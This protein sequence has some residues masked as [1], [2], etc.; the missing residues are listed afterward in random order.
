MTSRI[1]DRSKLSYI[2]QSSKM[3]LTFSILFK[4]GHSGYVE[5]TLKLNAKLFNL[6]GLMVIR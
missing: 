2:N 1:M 6:I 4:N 3:Q 5:K